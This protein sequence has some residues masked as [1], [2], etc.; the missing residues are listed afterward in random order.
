[1]KKKLSILTLCLLF[2]LT[3]CN[4]STNNINRTDK[5]IPKIRVTKMK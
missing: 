5:P 2:A 3:G 4:N 1:M